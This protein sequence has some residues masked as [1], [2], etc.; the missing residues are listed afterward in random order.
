[1]VSDQ[2]SNAQVFARLIRSKADVLMWSE[3][4]ELRLINGCCVDAIHERCS[5]TPKERERD[6][7]IEQ[8]FV[9]TMI[10]EG[11]DTLMIRCEMERCVV[12]G[13]TS[14]DIGLSIKKELDESMKTVS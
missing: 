7:Y 12:V 1:M 11:R 3:S 10:E 6:A 5:Q 9:G 13:I 4:D 2:F 14:I 8:R